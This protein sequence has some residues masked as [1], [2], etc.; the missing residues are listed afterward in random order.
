MRAQCQN[1][2]RSDQIVNLLWIEHGKVPEK[3]IEHRNTSDCTQMDMG[4]NG[5]LEDKDRQ[6]WNLGKNLFAD[7]GSYQLLQWERDVLKR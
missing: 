4:L 2:I 1:G 7:V 6:L 3:Q 5:T